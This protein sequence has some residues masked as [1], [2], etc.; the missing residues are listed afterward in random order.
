[1]KFTVLVENS[2]SREDLKAQ[3]GLSIFI[4]YND[5]RILLDAGQNKLFAENAKV[6]GIDLTSIDSV[7]CSH[8]H[9]DHVGGLNTFCTINSQSPLYTYWNGKSDYLSTTHCAP[10][11]KERKIGFYLDNQYKDRLRLLYGTGVYSLC[12]GVWL[13]P[14]GSSVLS[15]EMQFGCPYKNKTLF[16]RCSNEDGM[17]RDFFNHECALVCKN[18]DGKFVIFNSCSHNG[19]LNT[20]SIVKKTVP[21]VGRGKI[22]AYIG[23]FHFPWALG[24]TIAAEDI[25]NMNELANAITDDSS[26]FAGIQLY[27]AHCTGD[28]AIAY[29]KGK[30]GNYFTRLSTGFSKKI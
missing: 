8:A 18:G 14:V 11:E 4:E 29:L 19:V 12:E 7:V 20:I 9:Y 3:H 15:G 5:H 10:S 16:E 24:E 1:M 13:V 6:L 17:H 2:T 26:E 30:L 25:T 28:A 21:E 27:S 22:V 23:G